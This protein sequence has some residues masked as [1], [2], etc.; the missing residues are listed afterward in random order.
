MRDKLT[1]PLATIFRDRRRSESEQTF[2]TDI[3][4]DYASDQPE[5]GGLADGC[6]PKAYAGF[7]P[8]AQRQE[9]KTLPLFQAE[10]A[11]KATIVE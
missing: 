8:I 9:A 11:K 3:L 6:R 2:A 4:T 5:S 10:I 7:F 1:A